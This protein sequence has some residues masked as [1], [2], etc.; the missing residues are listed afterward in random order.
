MAPLK[1]VLDGTSSITR[2]PERAALRFIVKANGKTRE[3]VSKEVT[4]T[5]NEI[6]RLFK[7]LAPKTETGETIQGS[8][9]T[10]FSSTSLRTWSEVPSDKSGKPLP[11]KYHATLSL[12]ALFQDF[13]KLSE[14]VGKLFS[15]PNIEIQFLDWCLTEATQ[16]A[17]SSE[18]REEAMRD[19]VR[20]ANDYARVIGREV[21]AVEIREPAGG[22]QFGMNGGRY[23][24]YMQGQMTQQM[25]HQYQQKMARS[26]IPPAVG[27]SPAPNLNLDSGAPALDLSPQLI[28]Y[29]NYVEVEFQAAYN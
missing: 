16:N 4:E 13:T 28:R 19:A 14:V 26:T 22:L 24:P 27:S 18:S 9:V 29:T 25:A 23:N 3:S 1:I 5:S 6:N 12:N 7:D 10:S 17:L 11:T 20:K 2:Q 8:P 21:V 15:Y